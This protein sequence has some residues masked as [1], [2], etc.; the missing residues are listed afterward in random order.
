MKNK[1]Q[2]VIGYKDPKCILGWTNR[3]FYKGFDLSVSIDGR[4]GV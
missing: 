2:S 1:Y 4:I 3:F